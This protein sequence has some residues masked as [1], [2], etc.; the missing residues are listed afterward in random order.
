MCYWTSYTLFG[1]TLVA[2][3]E[4]IPCD[5]QSDGSGYLTMTMLTLVD[6]VR[7]CAWYDIAYTAR[8]IDRC[9]SHEYDLLL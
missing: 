6:I 5:V 7:W 4:V 3:V 9:Y 8:H 2:I 1:I